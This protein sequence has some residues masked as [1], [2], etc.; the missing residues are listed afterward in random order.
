IVFKTLSSVGEQVTS[1]SASIG[2]TPASTAVTISP[3]FTSTTPES[4][5]F[6]GTSIPLSP[7]TLNPTPSSSSS[8]AIQPQSTFSSANY[9]TTTVLGP[10]A[11]ALSSS[12]SN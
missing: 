10:L 8:I 5:A 6:N 12:N 7:G 1:T 3:G 4:P 2:A 9:A 11:L